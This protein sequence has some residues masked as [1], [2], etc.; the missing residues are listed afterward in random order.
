MKSSVGEKEEFLMENLDN[1]E[2][3]FIVF[4][5]MIFNDFFEDLIKIF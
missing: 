1:F 3:L 4:N 2:C 5:F